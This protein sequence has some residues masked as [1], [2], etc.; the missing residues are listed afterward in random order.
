MSYLT[1]TLLIKGK[2]LPDQ[3]L[4][5]F[6]QKL[7]KREVWKYLRND[8]LMRKVKR[9]LVKHHLCFYMKRIVK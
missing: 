9:Y 5:D 7:E 4:K 1:N 8:N 6:A 3:G 2:S